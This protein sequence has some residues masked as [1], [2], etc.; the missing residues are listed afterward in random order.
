MISQDQVT[1]LT[2]QTAVATQ[3][4]VDFYVGDAYDQNE[5]LNTN[6]V[7]NNENV[8]V[9]LGTLISK[10]GVGVYGQTPES[11]I[12]AGFLK[13]GTTSLITDPVLTAVVLNTPAVW[14]GQFGINS[15]LDYLNY[16]ILQNLT[17]IS[18][19]TG[20]YQSL[21]DVGILNG[22]E[23]AKFQATFVQ[24][25]AQFGIESVVNWVA[26]T[27]DPDTVTKVK[28]AARQAQYAIDF[29]ETY[30]PELNLSVDVPGYTNTVDRTDVDAAVTEIID[31]QKIPDIEY[32]DLPVVGVTAGVQTAAGAAIPGVTDEDGTFR[33]APNNTNR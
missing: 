13:P 5:T 12:L 1:A 9:Y 25:T 28:I 11:L 20:A 2:A 8:P 7:L 18:L 30:G 26:G 14:T 15:L 29:V 27:A 16:P 32:A 10:T 19:L 3:A 22:N 4:L 6:W 31:N 24:P 17:Q 21:L 23:S 33:F